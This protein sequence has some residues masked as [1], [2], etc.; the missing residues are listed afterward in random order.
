[1]RPSRLPTISIG[2]T[3]PSSLKGPERDPRRPRDSHVGRTAEA[4]NQTIGGIRSVERG[5]LMEHLVKVEL[6]RFKP[7]LFVRIAMH[8]APEI[9]DKHQGNRAASR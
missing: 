9:L 3:T 1:M 4:P 6:R 5:K 8:M 2:V 7:V